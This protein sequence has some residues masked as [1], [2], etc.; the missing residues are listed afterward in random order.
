[1]Q[2]CWSIVTAAVGTA[3]FWSGTPVLIHTKTLRSVPFELTTTSSVVSVW[4]L[5]VRSH[6]GLADM[7]MDLAAGAL[8]VNA[9][10]PSIVPP[11]SSGETMGPV[12][13]VS[14]GLSLPQLERVRVQIRIVPIRKMCIQCDDTMPRE[15]EL[16]SSRS[17]VCYP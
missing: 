9:T 12:R 2:D 13:S 1:M 17:D 11:A 10:L 3:Q 15:V 8:P 14:A 16:C 4:P 6:C 5:C 7:S